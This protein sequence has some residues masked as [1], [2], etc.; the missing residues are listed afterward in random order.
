MQI[1]Y[2]WLHNIEGVGLFLA[3]FGII[4]LITLFLYWIGKR[5][6]PHNPTKEKTTTYACGEDLP[7]IKA[8][9]H[10]HLLRYAVYFTI[11]DIVAFILATSM[12]VLG[13]VPLIY[14]LIAIVAV[15]ILRK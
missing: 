11:F 1:D 15:L 5:L 3:A 4:I 9:F 14:V 12:G 6:A 2:S 8:Q 13:W 10:T 7:A